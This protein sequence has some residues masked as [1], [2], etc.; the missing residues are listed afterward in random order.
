[1]RNGRRKGLRVRIGTRDF[2]GAGGCYPS[3]PGERDSGGTRGQCTCRAPVRKY[4]LKLNQ[5]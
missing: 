1:M 3:I 4:R 2:G 5:K